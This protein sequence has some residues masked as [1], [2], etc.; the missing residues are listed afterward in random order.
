MQPILVVDLL[1]GGLLAVLCLGMAI[2][3]TG[4]IGVWALD[5]LDKWYARRRSL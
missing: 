5:R 3:L 2:Y 4:R 1:I